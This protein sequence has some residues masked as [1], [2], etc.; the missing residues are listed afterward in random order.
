MTNR[1]SDALRREQALF[2]IGAK[3]DSTEFAGAEN[4]EIFVSKFV[5]HGGTIVME[6]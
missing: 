3:K 1:G 5:W 4:R 6:E 2:K